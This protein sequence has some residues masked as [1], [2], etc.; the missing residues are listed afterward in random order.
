MPMSSSYKKS[1][2]STL[3]TLRT[4][5]DGR[6]SRNTSGH[7]GN[8]ILSKYP[9]VGW[10]NL[11]I[12][13]HR[14]ERR[15]ILHATLDVP[16]HECAVHCLCL[17]FGLS[18]K[19]RR[20]Q[21]DR[22]VRRVNHAVPHDEPLLIAGDFNDWSRRATTV[23]ERDVDAHEVYRRVHGSHPKTFPSRFPMLPLDRIYARGFA[24]DAARVMR[25]KPWNTL[26][27]HAALY[28]ELSWKDE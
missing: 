8:A 24:V 16:G 27:D 6:M 7:H 18:E 2:A 4:S 23:L 11:D 3:T 19:G 21:I 22:L 26:S 28:A 5:R 10:E 9:I 12:S 15:G 14:F 13:M 20:G 25:G 1:L 17:H